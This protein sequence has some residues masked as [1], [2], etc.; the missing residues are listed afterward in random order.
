[1]LLGMRANVCSIPFKL[2]L[3]MR[4]NVC[5]H[6]F[7]LSLLSLLSSHVFLTILVILLFYDACFFG[8]V[9]TLMLIILVLAKN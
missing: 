4:V 9:A 1:M 7:L 8:I 2:P 6:P 3:N 5:Y